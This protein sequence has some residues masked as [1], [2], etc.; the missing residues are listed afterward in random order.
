MTVVMGILNVTPDSFSDG[1]LFA[2]VEQAVARGIQMHAE[3]AD[4]VDVGG[5]STRPGAERISA[6]EEQRRVLP[7]I[8]ELVASGIAVS[9]DT[10]NAQ[11]AL[12]AADAGVAVINDVSGGL[13][14]REMY[15]AVADTGL[16]YIAMHWRGV[17]SDQ[18]A[19][20]ADV[21][22][23]VR[24]ELTVRLSEMAESGIDPGRVVLDPGLG[25][26]K[27]AEHNWQLLGRLDELA[28]LGHPLLIGASRK[29]FL[30]QFAPE[31]APASAR[32]AA[33]VVVAALAARSGVWGVRVHDVEETRVALRVA[34][35]WTNGAR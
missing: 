30:V 18:R 5:E 3:G 27:N 14:D 32:D 11:T 22:T 19:D 35:A 4:F 9:I 16:T 29:R 28:S 15:R 6:E 8:R 23:D 25:F 13:V 21:V 24:A 7:V 20:Y 33:S 31:G 34:D 2:D 17:G 26:A 12:A 10:M 1:G